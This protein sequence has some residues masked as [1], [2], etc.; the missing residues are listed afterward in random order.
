M[1]VPVWVR[2][3]DS[4]RATPKSATFTVLSASRMMFAGLMSRWVTPWRW[5]CPS[6]SSSCPM[7]CP[8]IGRGMRSSAS[9]RS[10]SSRPC[11]NSIA[12]KAV[13]SSASPYS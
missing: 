3:D 12:M 6:A 13:P 11:T 5:A 10:F 7:S 9:N 8:T 2:F 4:I 1:T